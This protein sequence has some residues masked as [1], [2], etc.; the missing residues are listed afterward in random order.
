MART[1]K[2]MALLAGPLLI[3]VTRI[4]GCHLTEGENLVEYWP[5]YLAGVIVSLG[6][7]WIYLKVPTEDG[8]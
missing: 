1:L 2:A 4:K 8:E 7:L 5:Q 3:V 6:G